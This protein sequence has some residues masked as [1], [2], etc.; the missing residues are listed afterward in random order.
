MIACVGVV[1]VLEAVA[2]MMALLS[3]RVVHNLDSSGKKAEPGRPSDPPA[4]TSVLAA[5]A[6]YYKQAA[7]HLEKQAPY[8]QAVA[9]TLCRAMRR[10]LLRGSW[11]LS[12]PVVVEQFVASIA[13]RKPRLARTRQTLAEMES[14]LDR[15]R[16]TWSE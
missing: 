13:P 16:L 15:A 9:D 14:A 6:A 7:Y 1:Q 3:G 12:S 8:N 2:N 5:V 10:L 4:D 11:V